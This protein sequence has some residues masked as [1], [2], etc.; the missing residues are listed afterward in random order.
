MMS[1]VARAPANITVGAGGRGIL[2]EP[3]APPGARL[4]SLKASHEPVEEACCQG[5]G[6]RE[7]HD[8]GWSCF[9]VDFHEG[10]LHARQGRATVRLRPFSCGP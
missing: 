1:A 5:K 4:S 2:L 6:S 9:Q 3:G 7:G 8:I 10:R